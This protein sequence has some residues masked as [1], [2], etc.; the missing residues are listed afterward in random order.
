LLFIPEIGVLYF[1]CEFKKYVNY[2]NLIY[3][4]HPRLP[5]STFK[6]PLKIVHGC[7]DYR[8]EEELL[9]NVDDVL[10]ISGL[11]RFFIELM[12]RAEIITRNRGYLISQ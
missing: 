2:A 7:K 9:K 10:K 6:N 12:S 11:E 5:S 4:N 8:E 3:S 1:W